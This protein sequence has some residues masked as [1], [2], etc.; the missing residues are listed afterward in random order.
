MVEKMIEDYLVKK[1]E[2]L[3]GKC[4]KWACPGWSGVPDRIILMPQG[5]VFFV[6]TKAPLRKLRKRQE[7]RKTQLEELGFTVLVIDGK[8]K[9]DRLVESLADGKHMHFKE[10]EFIDLRERIENGKV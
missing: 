10:K 8:Q 6:E 2:S 5:K 1:I 7:F 4:K 9:V 3:G